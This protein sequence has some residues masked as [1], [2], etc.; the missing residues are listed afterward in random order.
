MI[1]VL[2]CLG[3][4]ELGEVGRSQREE[5]YGGNRLFDSEPL[6]PH[7]GLYHQGCLHSEI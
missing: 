5:G 1:Q 6:K 2:Y 7:V 3:D 4:P